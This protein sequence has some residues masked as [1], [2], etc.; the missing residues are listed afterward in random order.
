VD[1]RPPNLWFTG[2][3]ALL[4]AIV[5]LGFFWQARTIDS[6]HE[7]QDQLVAVIDDQE[8][9]VARYRAEQVQ[10]RQQLCDLFLTIAEEI[11]EPTGIDLTQEILVSFE[12]EGIQC[13]VPVNP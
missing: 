2:A 9:L 13:R 10:M 3:Y 4:V 7:T 5:A 6:L 11:E 12:R 1:R 8:E